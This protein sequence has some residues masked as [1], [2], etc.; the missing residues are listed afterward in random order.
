MVER[1]AVK[2]V[3][4]WVGLMGRRLDLRLVGMTASLLVETMAAKSDE[5]MVAKSDEMMVDSTVRNWAAHLEHWM[6]GKM[7]ES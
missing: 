5:M 2:M 4:L 3:L 7:V 6:V 1:M